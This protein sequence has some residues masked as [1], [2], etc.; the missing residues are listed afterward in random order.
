MS[1]ATIIAAIEAALE[2]GATSVTDENGRTV[3]YGSRAD[4]LDALA[5]LYA[6]Q[7][8]SSAGRAFAINT[9]KSSRAR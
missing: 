4:M 1:T 9:F 8:T 6:G 3:A 2:V 5:R 7:N